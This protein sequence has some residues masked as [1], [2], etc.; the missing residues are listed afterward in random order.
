MILLRQS[1]ASQ[2]V[3]L[4]PFVSA[5]D[6]VTLMDSLTINAADILLSKGGAALAAKNSGGGTY[7]TAGYYT[8]TL[9]ATDSSTVGP[10][11]IACNMTGA[12]PVFMDM[13]VIEEAAYD[14]LYA[15][16]ATGPLVV[17]TNYRFTNNNTGAGFDDVT[18]TEAP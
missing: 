3:K 12:L 2:T 11:Q 18:V 17:G 1:T 13:Q 6:G 16:G 14:A 4:G 10:L 15:S 5:S 7:D 8:I 9:D